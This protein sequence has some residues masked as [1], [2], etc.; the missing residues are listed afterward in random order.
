MVKVQTL[1]FVFDIY[2]EPFGNLNLLSRCIAMELIESYQ[3]LKYPNYHLCMCQ[4]KTTPT[5][6]YICLLISNTLYS[7]TEKQKYLILAIGD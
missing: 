3:L 2:I 1:F 4:I 7:Q 5:N 6:Q